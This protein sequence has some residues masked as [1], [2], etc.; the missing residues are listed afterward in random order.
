MP[1]I[2]GRAS[3][4]DGTPSGIL[5]GVYATLLIPISASKMD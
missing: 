5:T 1:T 2:D 4:V 3:V